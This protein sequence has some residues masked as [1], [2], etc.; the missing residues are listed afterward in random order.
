MELLCEH[1][2]SFLIWRA[3]EHVRVLEILLFNSSAL[4]PLRPAC[5]SQMLLHSFLL[6]RD[7]RVRSEQPRRKPRI[8]R[9]SA[10]CGAALAAAASSTPWLAGSRRAAPGSAEGGGSR[11]ETSSI[12]SSPARAARIACGGSAGAERSGAARTPL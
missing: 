11:S 3:V 1:Q 6:R 8:A 4:S 10:G 9:D 2:T 12:G 7:R 5:Y